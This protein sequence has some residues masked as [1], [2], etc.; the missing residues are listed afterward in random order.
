MGHTVGSVLFYRNEP[1]T[2]LWSLCAS[3][4]VFMFGAISFIRAGRPEDTALAWVCLA[5]GIA[6]LAASLRFAGLI[7]NY[8][9]FR[10][11]LFSLVSIGICLFC[12]RTLI[13]KHNS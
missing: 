3:L 4:F 1:M 10:P 9:D 11:V 5:A 12:L 13:R 6:W 2:M 7:G 8:F